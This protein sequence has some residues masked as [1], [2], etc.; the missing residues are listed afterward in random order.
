MLG[1]VGGGWGRSVV[2]LMEGDREGVG[3][4]GGCTHV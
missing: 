4:W 3:I 2:G 1:W